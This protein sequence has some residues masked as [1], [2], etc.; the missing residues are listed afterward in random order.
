MRV[1]YQKSLC[2]LSES[3][4]PLR[5]LDESRRVGTSSDTLILSLDGERKLQTTIF[6]RIACNPLAPS[7]ERFRERGHIADTLD[8]RLRWNDKAGIFE[9]IA[10]KNIYKKVLRFAFGILLLALP[11][12]A[13][14]NIPPSND[15]Q[16]TPTPTIETA[17]TPTP[18][19]APDSTATPTPID[20]SLPFTIPTTTPTPAPTSIPTPTPTPAPL[21]TPTNKPPEPPAPTSLRVTTLSIV[22]SQK[23]TVSFEVEL[24]VTPEQFQTGL[25]NRKSLPE[26]RGMLFD[27]SIYGGSVN[28]P[29]YMRNTLIPLSI[30]FISGDGRIVD[31]Q[32]MQPLSEAL[33]YPSALYNYALEVNQ[34]WFQKYG[35]KVGDTV[36]F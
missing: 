17:L 18:S 7:G 16:A 21:P 33:H 29:F 11:L 36:K 20:S 24:A 12:F 14:A 23:K 25:M 27:F 6:R 30:A 31:I 26:M 5:S 34:G 28:A 22:N 13:C 19:P 3:G 2:P 32:D 35:I 1:S 4:S 15:N 9:G 8:S 10:A